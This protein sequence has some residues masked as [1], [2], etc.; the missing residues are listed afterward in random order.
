MSPPPTPWELMDRITSLERRVNALESAGEAL[1]LPSR[2]VFLSN[3]NRD[4]LIV[5]RRAGGVEFTIRHRNATSRTTTLIAH[6]W[7]TLGEAAALGEAL[8]RPDLLGP[9]IH[10]RPA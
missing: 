3:D 9:E 8:K 5:E 2:Y 1:V 4:E 6:Q 10:T 7:I